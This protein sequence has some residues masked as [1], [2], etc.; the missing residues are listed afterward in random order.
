M[1]WAVVVAAPR[2][3]VECRRRKACGVGHV[4]VAASDGGVCLFQYWIAIVADSVC[5]VGARFLAATQTESRSGDVAMDGQ[6][7]VR[8]SIVCK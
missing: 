5:F 3:Q 1:E 6:A 2:F 4:G 8:G 7:K